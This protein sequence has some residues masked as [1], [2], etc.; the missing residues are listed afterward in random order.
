M[1]RN[2]KIVPGGMYQEWSCLIDL[3]DDETAKSLERLANLKGW[4]EIQALEAKEMGFEELVEWSIPETDRLVLID[5]NYLVC[6]H[7][8]D[9]SMN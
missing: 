3:V 1:F 2:L 8:G 4:R 5:N 9:S 6:M 7:K